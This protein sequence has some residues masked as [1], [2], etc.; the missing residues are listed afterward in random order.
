MS[1]IIDTDVC[2]IGAGSGGLSVA[3]GASQMG[4]RT[5]LIEKGAMG[6][7][8]LNFGCVPSKA[9]L[10]A[11][12]A[13]QGARDA[14]RFGL[15]AMTPSVD[16]TQVRAHVRGVIAAIEPNDSQER[17]E[18][19]GVTVIR[20]A[21][22]FTGPTEVQA[23]DTRVRA[24]YFV[25]ATGSSPF[26]PPIPGLDAVPHFTN[27]TLFDIDR[28]VA[29]LIVIGGGPIGLEMA[30]AHRRLGA[31]VTVLEADRLLGKDDPEAATVVI[32]RLR[33]E[34]VDLREGAKVTGV[35]ARGEAGV[36]VTVEA[37]DGGVETIE[38]SDLLVAVGRVA[39]VEGLGL[40]AAGIAYDRRG[41]T[42]DRRLRTSARRVFAIGDAAGG[43]QFTHMAG[44]HAGVVIRQMLFKMLWAK[45]DDR[46]V[47]WVTYTDPEL[48]QVGLT[49]AAAVERFG[50]GGVRILR[51]SFEENDRAQA[52]RDTHGFV[53]AILDRKG[54]VLG[55]TL[56]GAHAGELLLP[57]A[58]AVQE[59]I[60]IAKLAGVIAPYPTRSEATKRAAGSAFTQALFSE[61]TRRIVRFLL[62]F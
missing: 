11:G 38:G 43:W 19:L 24:K 31:Q 54:R 51:W 8:C 21:A 25:I 6:G 58:L 2:V 33:A 46:A 60:K 47:P 56:V 10:A 23:G 9:L 41:V 27:E 32:E 17:F 49:E 30:Q 50:A 16:M 1:E 53:K 52:E 36:A 13:A 39:N 4:A 34:G 5:V 20:A 59:R 26:V 14:G 45:T 42:V 35:A 3:A 18:G 7:D 22:R 37:A 44:Y 40:D 15:A 28:A 61:R 29:H 62:R 55:A 57:W 48:A 12:G